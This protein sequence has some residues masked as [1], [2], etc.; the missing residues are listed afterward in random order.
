M[1]KYNVKNLKPFKSTWKTKGKTK[2]IRVPEQLS[3]RILE[4]A[5]KLD[6]E[7]LNNNDNFSL[8]T[9]KL[10][11]IIKNIETKETGYKNNSAGKLINDLKFI[12]H[13]LQ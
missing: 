4:I 1:N 9:E 3:D 11:N 13:L 7:S 10:K 12:S 2:V 6:N 5:H 8:V